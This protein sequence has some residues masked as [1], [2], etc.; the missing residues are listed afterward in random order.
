VAPPTFRSSLR[1]FAVVIV[2]A[3]AWHYAAPFIVLAAVIVAPVL[4]L[5]WREPRYPKTAFILYGF[6]SGSAPTFHV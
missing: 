3:V 1:Y 5:N 2:A 6:L 4:L